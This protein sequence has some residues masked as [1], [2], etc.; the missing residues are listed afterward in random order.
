MSAFVRIMKHKAKFGIRH[1]EKK[2]F[3]NHE[4]DLYYVKFAWQRRRETFCTYSSALAQAAEVAREIYMELRTLGWEAT[5]AKRKSQGGQLRQATTVGQFTSAIEAAYIGQA[6]T[7]ADYCRSFRRMVADIF[8]IERDNERYDHVKGGRNDWIAKVDAIVLSE[9]TAEK[10]QSWRASYI[11]K[12]GADFDKRR[13]AE[14]T[15]NALIRNARS[16]FSP[17]RL[18]VIAF[19]QPVVSPFTKIKLSSD[20]D[21]RY[22]STVDAGRLLADA[23][24]GLTD[25]PEVL[26]AFLLAI[27]CGLRRNEVDKLEW[28]AFGW[29]DSVIRIEPTRFLHVKSERSIGE[30]DIDEE[31]LSIFRGFYARRKGNFVIESDRE[32]RPR[33]AYS[34]YR[35]QKT[36]DDLIEWLRGQGIKAASPIHSLRK[37]FGSLVNQQYGIHAASAALRHA[38]IGI[39]SRHYIGKKGRTAVGLGA[40][41]AEKQKVISLSP[42][43]GGLSAPRSGHIQFTDLTRDLF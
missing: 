18:D 3:R 40:L 35:C 5:L 30:I 26:K 36:F 31:I 27:C 43:P 22:Q 24:V 19:D 32:A 4:G 9:I 39:T 14:R 42:V 21:M 13:S 11:A 12:A 33:A 41:L 29:Q 2:L 25:R 15:A 17:K 6:R 10:I 16:L 8:E 28:T 20:G 1:W 37:E 34:H 7:I 23:L 38:D